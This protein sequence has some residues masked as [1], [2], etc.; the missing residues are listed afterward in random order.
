MPIADSYPADPILTMPKPHSNARYCALQVLIA[1]L[2]DDLTLDLALTQQLPRLNEQRDQ[3]LA[4]RLAYGVLRYYTALDELADQLLRKPLRDKHPDLHLAMLLGLEQL[5]HMDLPAHAV[6]HST[7]ELARLAKKDWA[8]GMLNAVLRRFQREHASLLPPLQ[9]QPTL[10]YACP[11]WLLQRLQTDWPTQWETIAAANLQQPPM[12]LRVNLNR[13]SRADYLDKLNAGE[14]TGQPGSGIA[15]VCLSS[16]CSV[17]QLPGFAD[18]EVSVQDSAAQCAVPLLDLAAGQRV[19]DAC[20]APGGK[21]TQI[22]EAQQDLAHLT[23]LDIKPARMQKITEN[24]T[25]LGLECE[26]ICADLLA[27]DNRWEHHHYDRILLDAPCTASGVIRRH[28]DIKHRLEPAG[29]EHLAALQL[30]M[31]KR[32]W[33]ALLPGGMLVYVTCSVFAQENQQVVQHF[34]AQHA[35][36]SALPVYLPLGH[37]SGAGWQILPGPDNTDGLFFARLQKSA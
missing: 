7:V 22:L 3:A 18:G 2:T 21:T 28:P 23:A 6:I 1:V 25:R 31:L 14:L 35:D 34:V 36:A 30:Q 9:A 5:W 19:L 15:D 27:T 17:Q 16:P 24:L 29:I 8:T 33:P 13:I 20:A 32:L 10:R 4:Q 26:L 37:Q 12:W 11:E